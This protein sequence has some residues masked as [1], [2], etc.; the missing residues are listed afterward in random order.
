MQGTLGINNRVAWSS[1]GLR[2]E[3]KAEEL[4]GSPCVERRAV[5]EHTG[6]G[7]ESV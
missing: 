2:E 3:L 4:Q 6:W 1:P 7:R 5:G